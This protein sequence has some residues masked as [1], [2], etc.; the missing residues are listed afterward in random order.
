MP[1]FYPESRPGAVP[2]ERGQARV[3]FFDCLRPHSDWAMC[4]DSSRFVPPF[5]VMP[6]GVRPQAGPRISLEPGIQSLTKPGAPGRARAL[7]PGAPEPPPP[8]TKLGAC[9]VKLTRQ[10]GDA[11]L[12]IHK[13]PL[14]CCAFALGDAQL[15][16]KKG[17]LSLRL[18][19]VASFDIGDQTLLL[20]QAAQP[21]S[22]SIERAD[23]QLVV[24]RR[25]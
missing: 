8:A 18:Q 17:G 23:T 24:G 15:P 14:G 5:S 22:R 1:P 12:R 19:S 3:R 9:G 16:P 11:Y 10:F 20:D 4:R 2:N 13:P 7:L 6:P 25:G 21:L